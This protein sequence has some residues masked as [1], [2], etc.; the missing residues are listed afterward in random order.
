MQLKRKW[1]LGYCLDLVVEPKVMQ[2]YQQLLS[3]LSREDCPGYLATIHRHL[4]F[5]HHLYF[6]FC[7]NQIIIRSKLNSSMIDF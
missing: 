2:R 3:L 5:V 4:H 6:P 7:A 1:M